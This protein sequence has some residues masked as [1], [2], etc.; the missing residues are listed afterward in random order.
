MNQA[1]YVRR[2]VR[3]ISTVAIEAVLQ[4]VLKMP[5]EERAKRTELLPGVKAGEPNFEMFTTELVARLML[6]VT[7][8]R[9]ALPAW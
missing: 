9:A 3:Y 2:F 4:E 1:V 7:S 5:A 8:A 6:P